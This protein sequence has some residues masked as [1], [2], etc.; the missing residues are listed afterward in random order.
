MITYPALRIIL[1]HKG[2]TAL[3]RAFTATSPPAH[4][5]IRYFGD[6]LCEFIATAFHEPQA[7]VLGDLAR[8]EWT[9]AEVF[10]APDSMPLTHDDFASVEA[11]RWGTLCF[12]LSPSLRT[13]ALHSNAFQWWHAASEGLRRPGRWRS[14]K[15]THWALWRSQLTT[16]YR[17]LSDEEAW[18]LGA[19]A[20]GE[21]FASICAGLRA[22]RGKEAPSMRAARLLQNWAAAGWIVGF[23]TSSALQG[24][25]E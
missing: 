25:C 8:W 7:R 1:G 16:H 21:S 19:V 6:T 22:D 18:A 23:G 12:L 2:F 11:A 17:K 20:A 24:A 9:L 15:P 10:D 5:S 4:F 3:A 14:A 13:L